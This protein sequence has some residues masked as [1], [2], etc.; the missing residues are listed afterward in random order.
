MPMKLTPLRVERDRSN[1]EGWYPFKRFL[2]Y[3]GGAAHRQTVGRGESER[4]GAEGR[5]DRSFLV[6]CPLY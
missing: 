5:F 1:F 3:Q 6:E 4:R 2:P